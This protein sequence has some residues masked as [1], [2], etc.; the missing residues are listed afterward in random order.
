MCLN[1]AYAKMS[2][3]SNR[4]YNSA[5]LQEQDGNYE[6]ALKYITQA[7]RYSPDD[8]VLNI[9]QAGL[10]QTLGK[11]ESAISAYNNSHS[12]NHFPSLFS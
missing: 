9:K 12:Y 2:P 3:T 5:I 8:A 4:L 1:C 10:F 6:Q 11:Y 7:L